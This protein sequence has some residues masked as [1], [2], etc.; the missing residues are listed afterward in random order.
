MIV[1]KNSKL[2]LALFWGK[3]SLEKMF[4]YHLVKNKPSYTIKKLILQSGYIGFF[5]KRVPHDCSQKLKMTH[6]FF[7]GQK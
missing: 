4:N 7:L 6:C 3:K 1:M 2:H 5:S